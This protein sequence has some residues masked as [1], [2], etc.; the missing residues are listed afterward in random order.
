[1][2]QTHKPTTNP[3]P[4]RQAWPTIGFLI[5]FQA[6][7]LILTSALYMSQGLRLTVSSN[8]A[9][10]AGLVLV[11][12]FAA[13]IFFTFGYRVPAFSHSLLAT[14]L[15]VSS[16]IICASLSYV[17]FTLR[18]PLVDV[19]LAKADA[20]LGTPVPAIVGWVQ[21]RPLLNAVSVLMYYTLWPQIVMVV[22]LL[23]F[24]LQDFR[25]L[26]EFVFHFQVTAAITVLVATVTPA[27]GA[28]AWYGFT[29]GIDQTHV[30]QTIRGLRDGGLEQVVL[31]QL[32]GL[33]SFPS[34]HA[35]TAIVIAYSLRRHRRWFWPFVVLDAMM[36]FSTI[37]L[38]AH[39]MVDLLGAFV[40][41]GMSFFAFS[42]WLAWSW[43][44]GPYS[45]F[46][47]QPS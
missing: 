27:L 38:G 35:V 3:E 45:P 34:F 8:W 26:W 30:L 44:S 43:E 15:M 5:G 40:V 22:L 1:M 21:A 20:I 41:C 47:R 4:F 29:S 10:L 23:G 36:M 46:L 7:L 24:W 19:W 33:I 6:A 18:F 12:M 16:S 9:L 32:D 42:K 2:T 31:P 13:W 28:Y 11:P 14:L 17:L 39:Y 25:S 37:A